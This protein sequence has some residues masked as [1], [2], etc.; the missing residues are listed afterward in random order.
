MAPCGTITVGRWGSHDGKGTGKAHASTTLGNG[1]LKASAGPH[2]FPA[3]R[4]VEAK[5]AW[6]LDPSSRRTDGAAMAVAGATSGRREVNVPART[7]MSPSVTVRRSTE[8]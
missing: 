6:Q 8:R 1:R 4:A 3:P 5:S 7:P 2:A